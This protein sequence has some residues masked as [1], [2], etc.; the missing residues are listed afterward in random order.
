[1]RELQDLGDVIRRHAHNS[2]GPTGLD[3][4]MIQATDAPTPPR[5][6]LADPCLAVVVQ[7]RKRTAVGDGVFDYAAGEFLI[8]QLDLPVTGCVTE[9]SPELPFLGFGIRLDPTEVASL[10][11][12]SAQ[13][14]D[15]SVPEPSG[16]AVA[17]A[18]TRLL[19]AT[20]HLLGLLDSPQDAAVLAP[21]YRREVIWR[22]LTG[23]LGSLVR[24]IGLADGNLAHIARTL[25]WIR[26]HHRDPIRIEELAA[27]AGMSASTF[28][29][30]FRA[31]THMTP[32]QYQKAIRLREARVALV[33]SQ[34]DVAGTAHAVGYDSVSQF[35]REYRRAFGAPPGRDARRLRTEDSSIVATR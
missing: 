10:L 2:H 27:I 31:V 1:M 16:I 29:R 20:S 9:A 19:S 25:H 13:L 24:N 12:E 7:G 3:G 30:H 33:S 22:L 35:S 32:I 5:P 21:L 34:T 8:I 15:R 23:P 11:L 17:Q 18:D 26:E 14:P 6:G 28:H 4:V